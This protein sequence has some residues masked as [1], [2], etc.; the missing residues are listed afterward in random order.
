M[1]SVLTTSFPS[2]RSVMNKACWRCIFWDSFADIREAKGEGLCRC[3]PPTIE[4]RQEQSRAPYSGSER[5]LVWVTHTGWPRTL[6]TDWCGESMEQESE[7]TFWLID[8]KPSFGFP[9]SD[10]KM[11]I[12]IKDTCE[13]EETIPF[14]TH[15]SHGSLDFRQAD[16]KT[17]LKI[18]TDL[19]DPIVKDLQCLV[20][21]MRSQAFKWLRVGAPLNAD[22]HLRHYAN[23]I[24]NILL[25]YVPSEI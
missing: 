2:E 16:P 9:G 18:D 25:E 23:R 15:K 21:E 8:H 7:G 1:V 3:R 22:R 24:H 20:D 5:P 14:I 11:K 17:T 13:E 4:S 12:T 19:Q 10:V 6:G